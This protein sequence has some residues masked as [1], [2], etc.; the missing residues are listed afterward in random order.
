MNATRT[1]AKELGLT[2][3]GLRTLARAF[4]DPNGCATGS[5]E[6]YAGNSC[7]RPEQDG[8]VELVGTPNRR[9]AA[10]DGCHSEC[11]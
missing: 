11:L 2:V 6:G 7:Q 5:G 4:A 10:F 3:A 1:I 9:R 8:L